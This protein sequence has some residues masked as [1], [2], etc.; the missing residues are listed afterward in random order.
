MELM[1]NYGIM[2]LALIITI[3]SQAYISA[4]YAKTK[5]IKT[6][7][8]YS[9]SYVARMIL[10]K[11]GLS[12]IKINEIS[13]SLSDHYDPKNRVI[14]LSHDIYNGT[15]IASVSVA[16]HE[17][18]HAIQDKNGYSFLRLRNSFI[19]VVN[20]ASYAG[21]FAILFGILFSNNLI[22][23]GI[24][25]EVII[26]LFQIITLPVEFNAS[27]R[28]LKELDYLH[29]L[30]VDELETSKT[31]LTSAALT[32]VASTLN[33]VLQVLRLLLIFGRRED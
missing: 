3:I 5:T 12:D 21:Y 7:K 11:K 1:I 28:A 16:A 20:F 4:T 17:C 9:G 30:E 32:Y 18:G 2:F 13:G 22:F 26:L 19:P 31:M 6:K 33:A 24:F 23:I 15:S 27:K 14:N 25:M 29:V 8:N 10:D